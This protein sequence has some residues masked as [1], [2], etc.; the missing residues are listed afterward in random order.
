M[1]EPRLSV[2]VV[3]GVIIYPRLSHSW[4]AAPNGAGIGMSNAT[5]AV[6]PGTPK[7]GPPS[8][9]P[10][11]VI[12]TAANLRAMPS[13]GSRIVATLPRGAQVTPLEKHSNWVRIRLDSHDGKPARDGWVYSTSL[14]QITAH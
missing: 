12:T 7:P 10:G 11:F 13:G 5:A 8:A 1:L 3:A 14:K 9:P 6:H 2:L 4:T